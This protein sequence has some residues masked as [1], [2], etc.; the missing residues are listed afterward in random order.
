LRILHL[1]DLHLFAGRESSLRGAVTHDSLTQ[2]MNHYAG[3]RWTADA[4]LVTGDLVQD[5][6]PEAY[7]RCRRFLDTTPPPVQICAGNHDIPELIDATFTDERYV[8]G[9]TIDTD[10]WR[11]VSL[12][13]YVEGYAGGRLSDDELDRLTEALAT[14]RHVLIS[15]HHPPLDLG[16][17]WLDALKLDNAD[18][19]LRII[20]EH[21]NARVV[22]FGHA[23]QAFDA[24]HGSTRFLCTPSTGRQFLPGSDSFA[25]DD[26]PPAWR[27]LE[28]NADGSIETR[29][30]WVRDDDA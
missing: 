29:V 23:H 24:E 22:L 2:V 27:Q 18:A 7:R 14:E 26:R 15:L 4:T 5:D 16:S 3:T 28:L 21:R 30:H 10:H 1:T 6:T 12:S 17:R 11:L 9:G 8:V 13:T 25:T 20:H 19:F